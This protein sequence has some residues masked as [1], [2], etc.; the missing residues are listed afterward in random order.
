MVGLGA[1]KGVYPGLGAN[2]C[3]GANINLSAKVCLGAM[4]GLSA[5]GGSGDGF[6]I[7]DSSA[8]WLTIC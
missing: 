3:L 5:N 4:F 6:Y 8:S 2:C 1:N 7:Q